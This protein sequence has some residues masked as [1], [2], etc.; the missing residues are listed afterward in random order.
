MAGKVLLHFLRYHIGLV[1]AYSDTTDV[2]RNAIRKYASGKKNVV[3]LGVYQ[4]ATS[5][6]LRASMAHDG[7]L[8]CID[9]FEKDKLGFSYGL[10]IAKREVGKCNN[11][12]VHFIK[13]YSYDIVK[14]WNMKIDFL[15]IDADHGYTNVKKD[16][17]EWSV[18]VE[19]SGIVAFHDS[20][21]VNGRK[22]TMGSV[23]FVEELKKKNSRV[24]LVEQVET[25][26]VFQLSNE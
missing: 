1:K 10:T 3:E 13:G 16:W 17:N 19:R 22:P 26:S 2:E 18:F 23:V 25:L 5:R 15:F 8:W 24:K 4:G 7:N 20:V 9:P 21:A 11:G 12:T 6:V 14:K